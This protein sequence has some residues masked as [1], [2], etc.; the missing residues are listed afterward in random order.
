MEL[1]ED[2]SVLRMVRHFVCVWLSDC[3]AEF[4]KC[5]LAAKPLKIHTILDAVLGRH[6]TK[7]LRALQSIDEMMRIEQNNLNFGKG[8]GHY[9]ERKSAEMP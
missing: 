2:D 8:I 1:M 9:F 6:Y 3:V 4:E 7:Y 5:L